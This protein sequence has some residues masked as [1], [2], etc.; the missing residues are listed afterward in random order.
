MNNILDINSLSKN[1]GRKLALNSLNL[2]LEKGKIFGLLG[3]N[4]SGKTTLIKIIAGLLKESKGDILINGTKPGVESKKIVS[5]LPDE[6]YLYKWMKIKD[7]IEL[8]KDFYDDFDEEKM[9]QLLEFMKLNK[10]MKITSLSRGM[11][12]KLNLSLVLSRKAELYILDEPIAGVD[13]VAREKILDAIINNYNPDSS[14]II[15][16]HLVKDIERI[17]DDVAFISEGKIIKYGVAEDLRMEN[18]K[19]IDELYRDIFAE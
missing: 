15:T 4:G 18:N 14:M 12:E 10:E 6:G 19:S 7:A 11:S 5:Y 2:K 16:T 17:F 1:Y 9:N 3:P 8:F 13:P